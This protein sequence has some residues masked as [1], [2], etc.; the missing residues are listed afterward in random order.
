MTDNPDPQSLLEDM[1]D[2]VIS[3]PEFQRRFET[4]R[5]RQERETTLRNYLMHLGE[6]DLEQALDTFGFTQN[7]WSIQKTKFLDILEGRIDCV[8]DSDAIL[9]RLYRQIEKDKSLQE[10][11]GK[12]NS[13][14][15]RFDALDLHLVTHLRGYGIDTEK[16]WDS[17]LKNRFFLMMQERTKQDYGFCE[18]YHPGHRQR[19]EEYLRTGRP[20]KIPIPNTCSY[21]T[22]NNNPM[23]TECNGI[24][25]DNCLI[26][27]DFPATREYRAP[28]I[29]KNW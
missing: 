3:D 20:S 23:D 9:E 29:S 21:G 26:L 8:E 28:D 15:S 4:T 10:D 14:R 24:D 18:H 6:D 17:Y 16:T 25:R 5:D 12:A 1:F 13:W 7:Y 19:L 11:L 2:L 27:Q 22:P